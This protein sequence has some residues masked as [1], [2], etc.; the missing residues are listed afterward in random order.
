MQ[1]ER[2][3]GREHGGRLQAVPQDHHALARQAVAKLRRDRGDQRGRH[4]HDDGEQPNRR[5]AADAIGVDEDRDPGRPLRG[6]E[7]TERQLQPAEIRVPDNLPEHLH[8]VG[9]QLE[10]GQS[11]ADRLLDLRG[12][13]R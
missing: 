9:L 5:R 7:T 1:R 13:R 6:V 11:L 3:A 12:D 8:A 2:K 4:E 10:P